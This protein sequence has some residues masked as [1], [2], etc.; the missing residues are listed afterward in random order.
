MRDIG[1]NERARVINYAF[2]SVDARD[3]RYVPISAAFPRCIYDFGTRGS[4]RVA[5]RSI[6]YFLGWL[7]IN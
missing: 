2:L 5:S 1:E 4:L 6:M 7:C 3:R